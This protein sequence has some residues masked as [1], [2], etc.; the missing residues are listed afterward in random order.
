M[1][2]IGAVPAFAPAPWGTRW[3]P[4]APLFLGASN[5]PEEEDR[6]RGAKIVPIARIECFVSAIVFLFPPPAASMTSPRPY[7]GR[8]A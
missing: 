8:G 1:A 7:R 2:R 4:V 3:T 6:A 5:R